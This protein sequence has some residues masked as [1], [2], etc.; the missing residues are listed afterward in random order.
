MS[1][2]ETNECTEAAPKKVSTTFKAA[3]EALARISMR[4]RK[5]IPLSERLQ[6]VSLFTTLAEEMGANID[7]DQQQCNIEISDEDW[8]A[9]KAEARVALAAS[10]FSMLA[11]HILG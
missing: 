2:A 3:A 8:L 4:R 10:G 1:Q 9:V 5:D 6:A 11:I 7:R